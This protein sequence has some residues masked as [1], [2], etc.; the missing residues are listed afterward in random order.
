[1]IM[2][3]DAVV[4]GAGMVG[5][6]VAKTLADAGFSTAVLERGAIAVEWNAAV[7]DTRV[8][9]L[10][11]GSERLLNAIG[12]WPQVEAMRVSRYDRMFVW[13][14]GSEGVIEFDSA[15]LGVSHLGSIVE[16]DLVKYAL[17]QGLIDATGVEVLSDS[18][19]EE[20]ECDADGVTVKLRGGDDVRGKLLIGADGAA[21]R[22]REVLQIPSEVRSYHQRAI[23]A[24]VATESGHGN[25]AWQR[26][27][28]TG[29]LAFLPL[30]NGESSIVWSCDGELADD[31]MA[32]GDREFM[33]KLSDAFD[34]K[35]GRVTR[36]GPRQAFALTSARA[37]RYV[38]QRT[39]LVG[40]AAH[41]VHPLAGQGVNLG[42]ADAAALTE[43][44]V[45]ARA[46][47]KDIGSRLTLRRYERWRKGD[48]L[49]MAYSLSGLK[50]LF[51]TRSAVAATLR[52]AG[53]RAVDVIGPLKSA[54]ARRAMG[55]SGDLP[56]IMH[57]YPE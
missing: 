21:S 2:E 1:M 6:T 19:L 33:Q 44:L 51:G 39:V 56:R 50:Q 24:Q 3:F 42:L 31:L 25:T 26:F 12:V 49:L 45:D 47:G 37:R 14:S 5:A 30:S 46:A 29:P 38:D 10:N 41:V 53:L 20:L 35:L 52:G 15:D 32:L 7:H 54:F 4:V 23:V 28:S 36:T 17:H 9:A 22:V 11:L 48:N 27:L 55:L 34:H 8:S 57:G 16:N 18:E 13:D 43:V 40:D